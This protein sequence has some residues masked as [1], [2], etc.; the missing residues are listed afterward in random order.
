SEANEQ[1]GEVAAVGQVG[2]L[3]LLASSRTETEERVYSHVIRINGALHPIQSVPSDL[4]ELPVVPL[5]NRPDR[6][7]FSGNQAG[8]QDGDR[9]RLAHRTWLF[10]RHGATSLGQGWIH[11]GST[12]KGYGTG[13]PSLLYTPVR[14]K[15]HKKRSLEDRWEAVAPV[16]GE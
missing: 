15:S 16:I 11:P 10:G 4:T 13:T 1:A 14:K 5:P 8:N 6:L 7:L 12:R 2:E 9:P 3:P